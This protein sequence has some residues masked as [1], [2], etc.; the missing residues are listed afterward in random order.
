MLFNLTK[1]CGTMGS[2]NFTSLM[3]NYGGDHTVWL[4][5]AAS[6]QYPGKTAF[7]DSGH[8][9]DVPT[10]TVGGMQGFLIHLAG[11]TVSETY[12]FNRDNPAALDFTTPRHVV[13]W[14]NGQS[15]TRYKIAPLFQNGGQKHD[16][17]RVFLP[18][19]PNVL[20]CQK[21][22]SRIQNILVFKAHCIYD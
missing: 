15:T 5:N 11:D 1:L 21:K 19:F 2:R 14:F 10:D 8:V 13:A 18:Q 20:G 9:K 3:S 4:L 6:N 22:T 7:G 17:K 12:E 16:L